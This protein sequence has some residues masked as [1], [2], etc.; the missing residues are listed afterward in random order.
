MEEDEGN[1]TDALLRDSD[2][3]QDINVEDRIGQRKRNRRPYKL[4]EEDDLVID[5]DD[6]ENL[7]FDDRVVSNGYST[8]GHKGINLAH[9]L[10]QYLKYP[11]SN[12]IHQGLLLLNTEAR[13]LTEGI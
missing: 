11:K 6:N 7:G 13:L 2:I 5:E 1:D 3:E 4:H 8:N 10:R 12:L 9:H